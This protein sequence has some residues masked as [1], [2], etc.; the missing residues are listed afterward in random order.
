MLLPFAKK[1]VSNSTKIIPPNQKKNVNVQ[2]VGIAGDCSE[3]ALAPIR[4][5]RQTEPVKQ[6]TQKKRA[7]FMKYF[8]QKK[9]NI[10]AN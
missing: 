3:A 7:I 10:C 8:Q 1:K 2:N 4:P 6:D 5:S 9:K